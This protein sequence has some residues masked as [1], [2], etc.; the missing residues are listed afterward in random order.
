VKTECQRRSAAKAVG[1]QFWRAFTLIEL[2]VVVAIVALVMTI[3]IP[4]IYRKLHPDSISKAVDDVMEACRYARGRAILEGTP[5]DL[6][7]RPGD[8][9]IE[10]VPATGSA[11][12]SGDEIGE[13]GVFSPSVSGKA[14]RMDD[15]PS[16]AGEGGGGGSIFSAKMSD[17]II[18]EGL[19]INGLDYT[20]DAVSRVRF[21]PNGTSDEMSLILLSDKNERRNITLEVVT[22]LADV[23]VDPNKFKHR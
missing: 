19:G 10:V 12:G 16:G 2:M 21:F 8:R 11:R 13:P 5:T 7:F 23:E 15:R 14:W 3:S 4:S 9:T 1:S 18:I 17:R 22:A 6:V 20:E